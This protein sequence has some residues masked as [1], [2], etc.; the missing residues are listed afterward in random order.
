MRLGINV[1]DEL[2]QR[3]KEIDP[4]LNISQVCREAIQARADLVDRARALVLNDISEID[5][6]ERELVLRPEPD[7]AALALE[8][9]SEWLRGVTPERWNRFLYESDFLRRQGRD[10]AEMVDLWSGDV[11]DAG[12][13]RRIAENEE[14]LI[15]RYEEQWATGS[16]DVNLRAQAYEK[17]SRAWLFYVNEARRMLEER[18]KEEYD[19]LMAE[20]E[21]HRRAI[22]KPEVPEHLL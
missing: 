19:K 11:S 14:W 5:R 10:Q 3:A 13:R 7:W 20:R 6:L 12:L 15:E 16:P 2:L 22:S 4:P 21:Q 9:A 18:R 17:Y 1:P 8:D